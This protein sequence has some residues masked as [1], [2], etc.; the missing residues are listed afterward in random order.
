[1]AGRNFLDLPE[2]ARLRIY[3]FSGLVRSCPVDLTPDQASSVTWHSRGDPEAR[4]ICYYQLRSS[5]KNKLGGRFRDCVCE[6]FPTELLLVSKAIYKDAHGVL[7]G[8]NK[9]VLRAHQ[10]SHLA[11]I[12]TMTPQ[13]ISAMTSLL[14]RL[15]CWPCPW[16][17]DY[18]H[19][20]KPT[21]YICSAAL[22]DCDP[23]LDLNTQDGQEMANLWRKLCSHLFTHITPDQLDLTFICD[24]GSQSDAEQITAPLTMLPLLKKCTIRLGRSPNPVL[25]SISRDV[26]KKLTQEFIPQKSFPFESLPRELRLQILNY[27]HL[28]A[29]GAYHPKFSVFHVEQNKLIYGQS[30]QID[31]PIC[32]SKC[33]HTFADCCCP[34]AYPSYSTSCDCR[35]MPWDLFTVSKQMQ[36]DAFEV[37]YSK[38]IFEFCQDPLTT[39]SFFQSLPPSSLPFIHRMKF[40]FS[41]EQLEEWDEEGWNEKWTELVEYIKSNMN[42]LRLEITIDLKQVFELF[43]FQDD[44]PDLE[45]DMRFIDE[46]YWHV[47]TTLSMLERLKNVKFELGWWKDMKGLLEQRVLE[48]RWKGELGRVENGPETQWDAPSWRVKE[49]ENLGVS[50]EILA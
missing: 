15:N 21:C 6:R 17:H 49:I 32:C 46:I 5:G 20:T 14:I 36:A 50:E 25:N 37:F 38:N 28:G 24:T 8:K 7:Y 45:E 26:S 19:P 10:A 41:E 4:N 33:T 34:T 43:L 31:R 11:A 12:A 18:L 35:L 27:T 1:M 9:F 23:I 48:E 16:G 2:A 30:E 13:A 22:E 40:R 3:K 29:L 47:A 39:L 44:N 42:L